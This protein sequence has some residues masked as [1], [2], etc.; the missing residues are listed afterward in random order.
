MFFPISLAIPSA[1]SIRP[2]LMNLFFR[3]RL[4]LSSGVMKSGSFE[5]IEIVFSG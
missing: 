4:A 3:R 1:S 2:V 5:V